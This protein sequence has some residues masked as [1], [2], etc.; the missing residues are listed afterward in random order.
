MVSSSSAAAGHIASAPPAPSVD[1][2]QGGLPGKGRRNLIVLGIA[3]I[4]VV[5]VVVIGLGA[6]NSP[7]SP[8]S[9]STTTS[10]SYAV[11]APSL[12]SSAAAHVPAGYLEGTSKALKPKEVG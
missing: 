8:A 5:A 4:I 12:I 10:T 2:A 7:S 3:T 1:S 11:D 6:F 9:P